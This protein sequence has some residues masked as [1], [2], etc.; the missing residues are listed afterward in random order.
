MPAA[1]R[2]IRPLGMNIQLEAITTTEATLPWAHLP[3]G[4][5]QLCSW[6]FGHCSWSV[7]SALRRPTIVWSGAGFATCPKVRS[8]TRVSPTP[9]QNISSARWAGSPTISLVPFTHSC[10]WPSFPVAGLRGPLYC[11]PCSSALAPSRAISH[12]A[13]LVR[14]RRRR[15]QN[16]QSNA[17][18]AESLMAHS[19]FGVGLYVCAVGVSHMLPVHA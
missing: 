2:S 10:S 4:L 12:H 15:I 14:T 11:L 8:R 9:R 1:G 18:Q 6:T 5:A 7:P 19:A 13:P 3:L 16:A 17:G